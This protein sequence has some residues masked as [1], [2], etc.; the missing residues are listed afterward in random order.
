[1]KG[2]ILAA[3]MGT[4]LKPWTDFHPK[5]LAPVGGVPMLERVITKM[6]TAGIN[7]ITVNVYHFADQIIEFVDSKGWKINISDER[8]ELLETGGALLN[9]SR[10]LEDEEP[11]LVHNADILSNSDF[12]QLEHEFKKKDPEALLL[13]SDR[14][15]SRKFLFDH[16]LKLK[17][18][19]NLNTDEYKPKAPV[20][21]GIFKELAFSG[22]YIISP[23]LITKMRQEGWNGKFSIIDFFLSSL[24][25]SDIIGYHQED[26]HLTDIGKPKALA[27]AQ[28]IFPDGI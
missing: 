21:E 11:I 8:P 26:L 19:H 17:G 13:V 25:H 16:N 15:S 6:H 20:E 9:A 10:Y 12:R 14:E 23:R 22:I 24:V 5:A 1:M 3:G 18:W 27:R 28:Q 4:R 7:D 2:F